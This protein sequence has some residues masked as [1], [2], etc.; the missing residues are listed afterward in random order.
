MAPN[1]IYR[2]GKSPAQR[3][4]DRLRCSSPDSARRVEDHRP[5]QASAE[6]V[7][8]RTITHVYFAGNQAAST[9]RAMPKGK[10]ILNMYGNDAKRRP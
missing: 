10:D 5:S 1:V 6:T 3:I 8:N 4:Q 2:D 9:D 7:P